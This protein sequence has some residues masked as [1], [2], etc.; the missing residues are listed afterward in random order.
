[1]TK[2]N[3]S[4]GAEL[5]QAIIDI[6]EGKPKKLRVKP[7]C[8]GG[9][10]LHLIFKAKPEAPSSPNLTETEIV[11]IMTDYAQR[12][13]ECPPCPFGINEE[14]IA[15]K[16]KECLEADTPLDPDYDWWAGLP[17]DAMA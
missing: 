7:K 16:L 17:P 6:M 3:N 9:L 12:F 8:E 11:Q 4:T 2:K 1:M 13:Q 15:I 10:G 14:A 5:P